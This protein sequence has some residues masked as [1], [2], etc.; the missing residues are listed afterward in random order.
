LRRNGRW[1]LFCPRCAAEVQGASDAPAR[2]RS[3]RLRAVLA[4][5]ERIPARLLSTFQV[6]ILAAIVGL[7]AGASILVEAVAGSGK[8]ATT[9]EGVCALIEAAPD[10]EQRAR[11]ILVCAF[12]KHIRKEMAARLPDGVGCSTIHGMGYRVL[13]YHLARGGQLA[14]S[15]SK[16]R[17]VIRAWA[18]HRVSCINEHPDDHKSELFAFTRDAMRALNSFR[19]GLV[20]D[21]N[22]TAAAVERRAEHYGHILDDTYA[23]LLGGAQRPSALVAEAVQDAL[24]EG[25]RLAREDRTID[26]TDMIY[27]PW[28]LDLRPYQR[29]YVFVDEAQD[30]SPAQL[31]IV[32]RHLYVTR[33]GKRIGRL[34]AV[35]DRHQ[36]IYG[37]A[38][39]DVGS[40]DRI[41]ARTNAQEYPLS[42]CY[43][44]ASSH[45]EL[46]R[47]IVPQIQDRPDAIEGEVIAL[48]HEGWI[49]AVELSG[50][51]LVISR[52]NAPLVGLLWRLWA[53]GI[54]ARMR[55]RDLSRRLRELVD[56]AVAANVTTPE[57]VIEHVQARANRALDALY[58]ADPDIDADDPR[59]VAIEDEADG[60]EGLIVAAAPATIDELYCAIER[61]AGSEDGEEMDSHTV[62]L[63]SIHRAKGDQA[64]RVV[65]LNA[66]RIALPSPIDWQAAQEENLRYIAYTRAKETLVLVESPP[67]G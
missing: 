49:D 36:A 32:L 11:D 54:R 10:P 53:R 7:R 33:E 13:S 35:G 56:G 41:I 42:V 45:L 19:V 25:E 6:A 3:D 9:V 50:G 22:I 34:V 46:A 16:Y 29:H 1:E 5:V 62:W 15:A 65:I 23:R 24:V 63:S 37:F 64:R 12:N 57:G 27:L 2:A 20:R 61:V 4:D 43:R 8:T 31:D 55:G 21:R 44:C 59:V 58:A 26:Y 14:M 38:G 40:I 60:I 66:D 30:L 47:T 67:R 48:G 52:T 18:E 51:D 28:R 39:A 17:A